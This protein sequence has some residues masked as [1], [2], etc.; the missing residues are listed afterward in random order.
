MNF[1][2]KRTNWSNFEL[3]IIKICVG[4]VGAAIGAYFHEY[5][6][7]YL[8]LLIAIYLVT[9]VWLFSRWYKQLKK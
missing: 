2:Q 1:L 8:F 5:L 7:G 3:G 9:G 6:Q 4:S